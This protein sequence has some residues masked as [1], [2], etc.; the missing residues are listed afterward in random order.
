[1]GRS[2]PLGS[3]HG[4]KERHSEGNTGRHLLL[5]LSAGCE[6]LAVKG[7]QGRAAAPMLLHFPPLGLLGLGAVLPPPQTTKHGTVLAWP[8]GAAAEPKHQARKHR[9]S[10]WPG[11][12][13]TAAAGEPRGIADWCDC[14]PA[15]SLLP[16]VCAAGQ[17][18][19]PAPAQPASGGTGP[20]QQ[21]S[22]EG[23]AAPVLQGEARERRAGARR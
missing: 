6:G 8:A 20:E 9:A 3:L 18:G 11:G 13:F 15:P 17:E 19:G 12:L 7:F 5:L 1:M 23:Q 2:H 16:A 10:P 21:R 22:K 4:G 14:L